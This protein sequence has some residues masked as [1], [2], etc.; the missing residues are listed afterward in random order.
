MGSSQRPVRGG[1]GRGPAPRAESL[2]VAIGADAPSVEHT[3]HC[4]FTTGK[5]LDGMVCATSTLRRIVAVSD[6]GVSIR[7]DSPKNQH[8]TRK[9]AIVTILRNC[10]QLYIESRVMSACL[11]DV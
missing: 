6:R 11:T 9:S 10:V 4:S 7:Q 1:R 8:V 5:R 2:K 3:R